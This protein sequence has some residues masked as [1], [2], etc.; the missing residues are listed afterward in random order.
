MEDGH[1]GAFAWLLLVCVPLFC[2][3][4]GQHLVIR[5]H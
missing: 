3:T 4:N 2:P 5:L 1:R